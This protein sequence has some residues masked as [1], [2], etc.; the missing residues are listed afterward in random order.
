MFF[1][2][3]SLLFCSW[4]FLSERHR[5]CVGK[6]VPF[7]AVTGVGRVVAL[8]NP[9]SFEMSLPAWAISL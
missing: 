2:V 9:A 6:R 3:E 4:F 5:Q 7:R 8:L 1:L